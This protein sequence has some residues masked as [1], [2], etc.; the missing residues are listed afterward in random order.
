MNNKEL[1]KK[2]IEAGFDYEKCARV[3]DSN[4]RE[5]VQMPKDLESLSRLEESV[6]SLMNVDNSSF[7]YWMVRA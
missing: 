2:A 7:H 4:G 6:P 1:L 3:R 5:A